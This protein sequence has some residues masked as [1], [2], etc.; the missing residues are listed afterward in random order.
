MRLRRRESR[1]EPAK[2]FRRYVYSARDGLG[3]AVESA[4][5]GGHGAQLV[6]LLSV[7]GPELHGATPDLELAA[8]FP[9]RR[10]SAEDLDD[11]E[12]IAAASHRPAGLW[13]RIASRRRGI[14]LT[15][16]GPVPERRARRGVAG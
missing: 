13:V 6:W 11:L 4:E 1:E 16:T 2:V 15:D 5:L 9:E 10:E 12:A 8:G 14:H 3:A 7:A